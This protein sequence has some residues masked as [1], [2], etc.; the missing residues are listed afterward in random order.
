MKRGYKT[1]KVEINVDEY[2]DMDYSVISGICLSYHGGV[3]EVDVSLDGENV[4]ESDELWH[5]SRF[6][7]VANF[8]DKLEDLM[9]R[10]DADLN[11]MSKG[12]RNNKG[13]QRK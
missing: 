4:R 11:E 8:R 6:F 3:N 1:Y 2:G 9:K 13:E 10:V 12:W 5:D 7:A